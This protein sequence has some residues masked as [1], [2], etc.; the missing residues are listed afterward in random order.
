MHATV[1]NVRT[2]IVIRPE[3]RVKLV[4]LA[5]RRSEKGFS[6]LIAEALDAYF[7]TQQGTERLRRR[8]LCAVGSLTDAEA[9]SLRHHSRQLRAK[10]R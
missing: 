4:E 6:S 8:A 3:H 5:A 1:A 9:E 7:E 10:W 2:T